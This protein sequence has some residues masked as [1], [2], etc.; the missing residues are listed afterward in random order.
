MPD[1]STSTADKSGCC[2]S[3]AED[4]SNEGTLLVK[5]KLVV[6]TPTETAHEV[7]QHNTTQLM[8]GLL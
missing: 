4:P 7:N 6:T 8:T 1:G 5:K 3:S 2:Q